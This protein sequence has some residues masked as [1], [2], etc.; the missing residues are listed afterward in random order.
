[1]ITDK[2]LQSAVQDAIAWEPLLHAAEIGVTAKDGV[3]SL[4]GEVNSYAKKIEAENA[5]KKVVGVKAVVEKIEVKYAHSWT[6][7]STQVADEVVAALKSNMSIPKD[8]ITVKVE[9]G[10]VT[11][12]GHLPWN[13]QREAAKIAIHHLPGV[14]GVTNDIKL[15]PD[16]HEEIEKNAV[17]HAI[18]RTWLLDS[19]DIEV[20]V[21]GSSVTLTGVIH[22]LYQKDE[23]ARVVWKTPGITQVKNELVVDYNYVL[24]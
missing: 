23:A 2:I 13:Y 1:M 16:T 18:A 3:V 4:T 5:A 7:S 24:V 8:R 22:S 11:L 10:W 9:D 14:R 21:S 20:T 15:K 12:E 6:K 17:E 19:N